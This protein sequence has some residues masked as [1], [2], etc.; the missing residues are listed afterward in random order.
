MT[1]YNG[2]FGG[3]YCPPLPAEGTV[4]YSVCNSTID[5]MAAS[6]FLPFLMSKMSA[7]SHGRRISLISCC[8]R[9]RWI[10]YFRSED[11]GMELERSTTFDRSAHVT[12]IC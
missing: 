1:G 3:K 6:R 4:G 10:V 12:G 9:V 7:A 8:L 11:K 2:T 5:F